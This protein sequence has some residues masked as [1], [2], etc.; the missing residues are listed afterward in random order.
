M[1]EHDDH[2][3]HEYEYETY[4]DDYYPEHEEHHESYHEEPHHLHLEPHTD[5]VDTKYGLAYEAEAKGKKV[6]PG[7]AHLKPRVPHSKDERLKIP[8]EKAKEHHAVAAQKEAAREAER[9]E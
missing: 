5:S 1:P 9:R 6:G 3:E 4:E 8:D 7:H 2:Y